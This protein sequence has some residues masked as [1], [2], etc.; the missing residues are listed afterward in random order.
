MVLKLRCILAIQ[1]LVHAV[2]QGT[3]FLDEPFGSGWSKGTTFLTF[4]TYNPRANN[5]YDQIPEDVLRLTDV[6]GGHKAAIE[7]LVDQPVSSGIDVR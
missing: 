2:S 7:Y 1:A 4:G 6:V 5:E 3:L